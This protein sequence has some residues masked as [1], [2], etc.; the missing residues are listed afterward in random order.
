MIKFI[1]YG[2]KWKTFIRIFFWFRVKC[3]LDR[4]NEIFA[5]KS[6]GLTK[7][8]E[9]PN[10]SGWILVDFLPEIKD[11]IYNRSAKVSVSYI[12][13]LGFGI[14]CRAINVYISECYQEIFF[15]LTVSVCHAEIIWETETETLMSQTQ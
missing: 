5:G 14:I 7:H 15:S 8:P 11:I 12:F 3:V 1:K 2:F 4:Q 6:R 10:F 13:F 9:T